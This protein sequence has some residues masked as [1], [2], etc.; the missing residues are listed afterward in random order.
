[1]EGQIDPFLRHLAPVSHFTILRC[2][3]SGR[4]RDWYFLLGQALKFAFYP[5]WGILGKIVRPAMQDSGTI[6]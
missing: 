3:L 4:Q 1:M 6:A 5:E 2:E